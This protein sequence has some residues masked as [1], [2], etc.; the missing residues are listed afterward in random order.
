M[1]GRDWMFEDLVL[2]A[3]EE[4]AGRLHLAAGAPP[5]MRRRGEDLMPV[6]KAIGPLEPARLARELSRLV[7]PEDWRRLELTGSGEVSVFCCAR[8]VRLSLY[9]ASGEWAAVAHL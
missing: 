2:R 9:R 8:V 6:D 4:G 5:L 7:E 1:T 3:E